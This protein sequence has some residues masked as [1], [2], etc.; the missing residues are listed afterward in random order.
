MRI[1]R[2]VQELKTAV[3]RIRQSEQTIG[4]VPTMGFL[5]E[6]HLSLVRAAR[7]ENDQVIVSIFVNPTQFAPHEDL[8]Q[9]PRDEQRD[10]A[11]LEQEKVNLVFIPAPQEIYPE[12]FSTFIQ[13]PALSLH[14]EGTTRPTHFRGVCTVVGILFNLVQ[15]DRA[16]FGQKDAQQA[17]VIRQMV[18]DLYFPLDIEICPIVRDKD[19]LA[20][21][22]RNI[23]LTEEQ[24]TQALSLSRTLTFGIEC[25]RQGELSA[26]KILEPCTKQLENTP[27]IRLD[28]LAIV[29]QHTFESVETVRDGNYFI[30][31]IFVG[32]TRLIDNM[33]FRV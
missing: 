10:C 19:G 27:G 32:S 4:F 17:A 23:Y 1:I 9:Y 6:G 33:I 25:A 26:R 21:S 20:L 5:H 24:R 7:Q 30:G 16:Y 28:Y 11:L 13:P 18:R 22:S 2:T 14:W 8:T 15:P 31:A 12:G 3:Q 29:N